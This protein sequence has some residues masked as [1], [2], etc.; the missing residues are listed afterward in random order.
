M[1]QLKNIFIAVAG[2][3]L[4]VAGWYLTKQLDRPSA[5]PL[6]SFDMMAAPLEAASGKM[7]LSQLAEPIKLLYFGYTFCPDACP[8][9][10]AKMTHTFKKLEA[11]EELKQVKFIFVS[12]DP[13]RDKP[14]RLNEYLTHFDAR[15]LGVTSDRQTIDRL[16]AKVGAAYHLHEPGAGGYYTIDH[17]T[18]FFV[19]DKNGKLIKTIDDSLSVNELA[20]EILSL[21]R[22]F[23]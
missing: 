3:S 2:V 12:V 10:V 16:A 18:R 6:P 17:T 5:P 11:A 20:K 1:N 13:Q 19:V 4:L 15:F 7:N 14:K 23:S 8:T 22:H 21:V 9:A